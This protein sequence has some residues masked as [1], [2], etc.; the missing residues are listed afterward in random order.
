MH[1]KESR[2]LQTAMEYLMTYGWAILIIGIVL[3]S[4]YELNVFTPSNYVSPVCT[5]PSGFTCAGNS[6]TGNGILTVNIEYTNTDPI[7]INQIG[8]NTNQTTAH[9][10]TYTSPIAMDTGENLTLTVQ[11][12]SGNSNFQGQIGS[13]LS[14][15]LL[16]NYTDTQTGFNNLIYGKIISK[17]TTS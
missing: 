13:M 1:G 10:T 4:L 12:Y 9:I 11:C 2:K 5:L 6:L 16:V 14:G 3:V 15:S 7:Q 17:V 8:C